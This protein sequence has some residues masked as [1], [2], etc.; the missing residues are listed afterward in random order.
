MLLT[1]SSSAH[2]TNTF[3]SYAPKNASY[4]RSLSLSH[5]LKRIFFQPT[6]QSQPQQRPLSPLVSPAALSSH[7]LSRSR[8]FGQN[9]HNVQP[10]TTTTTTI[11]PIQNND[12]ELDGSYDN[13]S[14]ILHE[15]FYNLPSSSSSSDISSSSEGDSSDD[16]GDSPKLPTIHH[17]RNYHHTIAA[18]PN[19][20]YKPSARLL[21]K[22]YVPSRTVPHSRSASPDLSPTRKQL[23]P[24]NHHS[25]PHQ[26]TLTWCTLSASTSLMGSQIL[27]AAPNDESVR[28]TK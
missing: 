28:S 4:S 12:N 22:A 16:E 2:A 3:Q 17:H 23:P 15:R 5:S 13:I 26:N 8:S 25:H 19:K 11:P 20:P 7:P 9:H 24:P 21:H 1:K 18:L 10:T 27:E 6:T 14:R